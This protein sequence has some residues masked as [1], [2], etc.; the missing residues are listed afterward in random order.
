MN[1]KKTAFLFSIFFLCIGGSME[2]AQTAGQEA[3]AKSVNSVLP[4]GV[5]PGVGPVLGDSAGNGGKR[6]LQGAGKEEDFP[7]GIPTEE[8]EGSFLQGLSLP[9]YMH[10]E[11]FSLFPPESH[12][13]LLTVM[14][15]KYSGTAL[16]VSSVLKGPK[17]AQY[18]GGMFLPHGYTQEAGN[19]MLSFNMAL[20]KT[21]NTMNEVFLN[22]LAECRQDTGMELPYNFLAV[23]M[24]HVEQ[25]HRVQENPRVYS[26]SLRPAISADGFILPLF[27]RGYVCNMDDAYRFLFLVSPDSE[28][29]LFSMAGLNLISQQESGIKTGKVQ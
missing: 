25:L 28:K 2:A 23:D 19:K 29:D 11:P 1:L 14:G 17:S 8:M 18:F 15:E 22:A 4:A 9:K 24:L 10:Y 13:G 16:T 20:M 7:S 5:F 26:F 3:P 6:F 27:I 12:G 21:E